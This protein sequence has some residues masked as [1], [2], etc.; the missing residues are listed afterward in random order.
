MNCEDETVL[1]YWGCLYHLNVSLSFGTKKKQFADLTFSYESS[2]NSLFSATLE[3]IGLHAFPNTKLFLL[4]GFH[5]S[6]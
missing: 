4:I 1:S 5:F 6:C 2:N 3:D